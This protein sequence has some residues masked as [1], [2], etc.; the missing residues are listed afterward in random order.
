MVNVVALTASAKP[1]VVDDIIKELDFIKPKICEK[2]YNDTH[3][4]KLSMKYTLS[5][6]IQDNNDLKVYFFNKV[7][8]IEGSKLGIFPST[9]NN[10]N[11]LYFNNEYLD[12]IK[13]YNKE[14][15]YAEDILKAIE[16]FKQVENIKSSDLNNIIGMIYLNI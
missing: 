11:Y 10:V 12:L 15:I 3:K 8:F 13:I 9:I 4:Y 1:E 6:Y 7:T 16:L 5:K 14:T 2:L